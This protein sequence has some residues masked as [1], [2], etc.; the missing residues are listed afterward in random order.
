VLDSL[1]DVLNRSTPLFPPFGKIVV[2]VA[3]FTVA[4]L[5]SRGS[6]ALFRRLLAWH[7]RR[8]I[9]SA[10]FDLAAARRRETLARVLRAAITA[11]AFATATVLAIG[12]VVGGV[13]RLSALVGASFLLVVAGFAI[14]RLLPD[15]VTGFFIVSERWYSVGD[16]ISIPL[17]ELE[18]VVEDVSL[19]RTKLRALN[20]D[21]IH[22][23]NSQIS[24]ARVLPRGA[25]QLDIELFVSDEEAGCE[26]VEEVVA[27]LPQGPTTFVRR[28]FIREI[29][30]LSQELT[31][32]SVR[33]SVAVGR[34]WLAERFFCDV[35][36][37]RA[38]NDLI[39]H[40]P[41]TLWVD[42]KAERSFARSTLA[43]TS[44]A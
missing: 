37:E 1:I 4:W 5:G 12:Q 22:V 33:A 14:N 24:A 44:P 10:R 11:A 41:V 19:R 39:V 31:R 15:A 42:E 2:I 21:I 38:A 9:S 18:G 29:E 36:K 43:A 23:H 13:D 34:D 16:T 25:R 28:P 3:V 6:G 7:D 17:F 30:P 20:G 40:G 27:L 8:D 35:L 32:L 26:L